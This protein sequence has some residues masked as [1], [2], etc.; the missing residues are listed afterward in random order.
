MLHVTN[1]DSAAGRLRDAGLPGDVLPW[2]D[3]LHEGPVPADAD[4][5]GLR[6]VRARFIARRGWAAED[7]V[8][9]DLE[10]RD[11]RLARAL[12]TREEIVLWFETDLYDM[13]QLA[14]IL[15]RLAPGA[16]TLGLVGEDE[17]VGVAQLAPAELRALFDGEP[18]RGRRVAVDAAVRDAGR[19]LWRALRSPDPSPLGAVASATAALPVLGDAARRHLEQFPSVASGVN[20][21]ERALLEAVRDGA[22]TP[23]EAFVAQQRCEE[24]PFL[25][26]ATAFDY[27]LVL[28]EGPDALLREN[29]G[30]TLTPLGED[31]L[32]GNA[33]WEGRPE[34]WLGGV[35]LPAGTSP[36]E[37]D[38][39][40]GRLV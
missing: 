5:D 15:D 7:A 30:L 17:F 31:V 13:L 28:G 33:R 8:R 3:I 23:V 24:R 14:Q 18:V 6:A 35:R 10:Q 40:L 9:R 34:R 39:A 4:D 29:G 27:L 21:T 22:R 19:A 16:A 12:A 26:D 1:G 20:R 36:W 37:W 2:R 25:G 38:P 11:A 32:A